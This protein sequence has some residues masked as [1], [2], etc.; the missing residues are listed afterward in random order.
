[1]RTENDPYV[2]CFSLG[3][4]FFVVSTLLS[5]VIA[6]TLIGGEGIGHAISQHA[7]YAI[8]QPFGTALPLAP[9][10]LTAWMAA[11]LARRKTMK[12]AWHCF[13]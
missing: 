2:V 13:A 6:R 11:S 7:Y 5:D 3:V 9:F 4:A 1:M 10:L 12:Q 8:T